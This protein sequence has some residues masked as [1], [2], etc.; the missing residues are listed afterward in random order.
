MRKTLIATLVLVAFSSCAFAQF[1]SVVN[2]VKKASDAFTPWSPEQENAIGQ[3]SAAKMIHVMGLIEDPA[4]NKYVQYVGS[5]VARQ[6]GRPVPYHFAILEA[7]TPAG[8]FTVSA[9]ALPGGYVFV[10]K[11]ALDH[12]TDEAQ[13]A[14]VLAHEI[15][16]VDGR[17]LE[18]AIQKKKAKG[19]AIEEGTSHIPGPSELKNIANN[20]ISAALL[21]Q[22][23]PKDEDEADKKGTQFAAGAGY[24][25]TGLKRFLEVLQAESQ[26]G[27]VTPQDTKLWGAT[28]PPI[29]DRIARL[30]S[31]TGAAPG[32]QTLPDRFKTGYEGKPVL[33]GATVPAATPAQ[34]PAASANASTPAQTTAPTNNATQSNNSTQPAQQDAQKKKKSLGGMVPH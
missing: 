11:G 15:A 4:L 25:A 5:T 13:L 1:G 27:K 21:E 29:G 33:A 12:M 10:T 6:A 31:Q 14:G 34:A 9:F 24:D 32:G 8:R 19:M 18:K 28:H 30:N 7:K 3:A 17:H 2:R 26:S 20:V 22:V 16:H 23:N